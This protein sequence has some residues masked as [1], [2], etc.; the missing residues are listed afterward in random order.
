MEIFVDQTIIK[1]IALLYLLQHLIGVHTSV[2]NR[3]TFQLKLS[4][5]IF[6]KSI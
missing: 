6:S 2:L 1:I 5:S 3:L 4:K